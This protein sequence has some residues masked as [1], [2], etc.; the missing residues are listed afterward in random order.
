MIPW[1]A[2]ASSQNPAAFDFCSISS[3]SF[4]RLEMSKAP[5]ELLETFFHVVGPP[6]GAVDDFLDF[7]RFHKS[8][9]PRR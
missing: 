1:A 3:F 6:A 8:F 7:R 9:R 4:S 2:L 5:P